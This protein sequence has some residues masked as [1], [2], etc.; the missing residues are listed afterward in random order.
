MGG[1]VTCHSNPN[2][3]MASLEI[4]A[5]CSPRKLGWFGGLHR[6]RSWNRWAIVVTDLK[7]KAATSMGSASCD[8]RTNSWPCA[9]AK[10]RSLHSARRRDVPE[11]TSGFLIRLADRSIT[12]PRSVLGDKHNPQDCNEGVV[13]RVPARVCR[14][15]SP[16]LAALSKSRHQKSSAS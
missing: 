2:K 16:G 6:R 8:R 9:S 4:T 3:L 11:R 1:R 5:E 14:L 10:T 15:G 7:G 13:L 12:R